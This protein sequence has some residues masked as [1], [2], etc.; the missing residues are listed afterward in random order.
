MKRIGQ[1]RSGRPAHARHANSG[2]TNPTTPKRDV[3]GGAEGGSGTVDR[4]QN[5]ACPWL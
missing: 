1:V 5:D 4:R 2:G 3:A